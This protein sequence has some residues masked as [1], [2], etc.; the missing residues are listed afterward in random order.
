MLQQEIRKE[1]GRPNMIRH[2]T[3]TFER[4]DILLTFVSALKIAPRAPL[5]PSLI[6]NAGTPFEGIDFDLQKSAATIPKPCLAQHDV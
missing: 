1:R 4:A 3:A 2:T 5:G 6:L